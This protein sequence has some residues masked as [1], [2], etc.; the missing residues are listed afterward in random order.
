MRRSRKV[1]EF[2]VHG[3]ADRLLA[4]EVASSPPIQHADGVETELLERAVTLV[5]FIP[6]NHPRERWRSFSHPTIRSVA[7]ALSM[8]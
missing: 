4:Y 8:R 2:E 7:A 3:V 5:R 6:R 1:E